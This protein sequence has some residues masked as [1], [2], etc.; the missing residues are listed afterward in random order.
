[1][2][3]TTRPRAVFAEQF[4][5]KRDKQVSPMQWRRRDRHITDERKRQGHWAP[6]EKRVIKPLTLEPHLQKFIHIDP[7]NNI[8]T[9]KD[10]RPTGHFEMATSACDNTLVDI[11]RPTGHFVGSLT[12]PRV[13]I[14]A[15]ATSHLPTSS[16][17]IGHKSVLAERLAALLRR[18]KNG[19]KEQGKR[20]VLKNHW[21][22][23]D[24]Y[25][26]A[27]QAGLSISIER[28][29]SPLNLH[30]PCKVISAYTQ[31]I[32]HLAQVE[33]P[34]AAD[35]L[36]RHNAILSMNLQRWT[37]LSDGLLPVQCIPELPHRQHLSC[38]IGPP[39]LTTVGCDTLLCTSS[40]RSVI[41][42]SDSRS[43]TTGRVVDCMVAT[44]TGMFCFLWWLMLPA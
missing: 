44:H 25:L 16:M 1:M 24:A 20:T 14:L 28:F 12:K 38:H 41:Q 27:M 13:C 10:I 5:I 30:Q 36:A 29:A 35:G 22:T 11:F 3:D 43:R 7:F 42:N 33:M 17:P 2:R 23:P 19:Y 4:R 31:Q 32:W 6:L 9:D 15:Q 21:A 34:T 39:Q 26:R 37:R 18:Y 40:Q 8:N